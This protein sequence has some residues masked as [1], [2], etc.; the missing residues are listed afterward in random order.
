MDG[1]K[2]CKN[3]K[4]LPILNLLEQYK[5]GLEKLLDAFNAAR[6]ATCTHLMTQLGKLI[7]QM[8]LYTLSDKEQAVVRLERKRIQELQSLFYERSRYQLNDL[9]EHAPKRSLLNR[10][11]KFL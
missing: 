3:E 5:K 6:Y 1:L 10:L 9:I 11:E 4:K 8:Q 2:C 7:Q